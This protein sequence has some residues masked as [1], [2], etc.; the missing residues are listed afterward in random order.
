MRCHLD[1]SPPWT[2]SPVPLSGGRCPFGAR[3]LVL[4]TEPRRASIPRRTGVE[5]SRR[6]WTARR[7][8]PEGSKRAVRQA[9]RRPIRPDTGRAAARLDGWD[10]GRRQ[11]PATGVRECLTAPARSATLPVDQMQRVRACRELRHHRRH[12]ACETIARGTGIRELSRLRRA[13]GLGNWGKRKGVAR[14]RLENG[15]IRLAE[16]HWYEAHGIGRREFKRKRYL[17]RQ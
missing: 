10:C 11:N 15:S 16:L 3:A 17:D 1:H 5:R 4:R 13:Y 9:A 2:A 12:C 6:R 8:L 14:I 7:L